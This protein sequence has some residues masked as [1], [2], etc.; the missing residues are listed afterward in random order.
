MLL[1]QLFLCWRWHLCLFIALQFQLLSSVTT[2]YP[3][4]ETPCLWESSC[5][6]L[7]QILDCLLPS[8]T[9]ARHKSK[10]NCRGDWSK[11]ESGCTMRVASNI[12]LSYIFRYL[13]WNSSDVLLPL[14][15]TWLSTKSSKELN[16]RVTL[17]GSRLNFYRV[18]SKASGANSLRTGSH[19]CG[20]V[21]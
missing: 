1:L 20:I 10:K 11:S 8:C 12:G 4:N 9:L 19:T 17:E 16:L 7:F 21:A 15:Y 18:A 2:S 6:L 3:D 14:L 5:K 13:V